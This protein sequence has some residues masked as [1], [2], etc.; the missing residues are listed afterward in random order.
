MP[1]AKKKQVKVIKGTEIDEFSDNVKKKRKH[2]SLQPQKKKKKPRMTI[3][4]I[5][6]VD[7]R[8]MKN[9]KAED[10]LP[11]FASTVAKPSKY[12]R[13]FFCSV[14][15]FEF[16]YT[17]IRCGEKFCSKRCGLIHKE[18]RCLKFTD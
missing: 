12:P 9:L 13:R 18:T 11:N 3:E 7:V 6:L 2:K 1:K 5:L 10:E 8:V 15:G 14:C 17:C 4:E 16:K